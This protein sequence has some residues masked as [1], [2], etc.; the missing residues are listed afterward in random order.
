[1]LACPT[2]ACAELRKALEDD[3]THSVDLVAE[4]TSAADAD[5]PE[6]VVCMICMQPWKRNANALVFACGHAFHEACYGNPTECL[7]C[8][9]AMI[10]TIDL[11][12]PD[13]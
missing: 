1:M 13:S 12:F 4:I 9:D 8:G 11:P 3:V 10:A 6:I 2:Q 7:L 5:D